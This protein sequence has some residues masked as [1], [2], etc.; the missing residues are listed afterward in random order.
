MWLASLYIRNGITH[1]DGVLLQWTSR[2]RCA[3]AVCYEPGCGSL[4][5]SSAQVVLWRGSPGRMVVGQWG[6]TRQFDDIWQLFWALGC[7]WVCI[8]VGHSSFLELSQISNSMQVKSWLSPFRVPCRGCF[9]QNGRVKECAKT[10]NVWFMSSSSTPCHTC[11][12]T[13]S[14][15]LK[16]TPFFPCFAG[17]SMMN[18]RAID[19][20][21]VGGSACTKHSPCQHKESPEALP[22]QQLME[23]AILLEVLPLEQQGDMDRTSRHE[24]ITFLWR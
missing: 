9:S 3:S 16:R 1:C 7:G 14:P 4:L 2:R 11:G 20:L 10:E 18:C 12:S 13:G 8:F 15:S 5:C 22:C 6:N 24:N 21:K 17:I 19:V 23:V